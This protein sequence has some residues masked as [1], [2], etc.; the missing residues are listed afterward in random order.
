M[1]LIKKIKIYNFLTPL[2]TLFFYFFSFGFVRADTIPYHMLEPIPGIG[3]DSTVTN[4]GVYLSQV[5]TISL[6]IATVLAVLMISYG[7]FK[8]IT[9][10]SFVGKSDAKKKIT[11]AIIGLVLLLV[12]WLLLYTINPDLVN[13]DFNIPSPAS[14]TTSFSGGGGGGGFVSNGSGGG[15]GGNGG[16]GG[17][18]FGGNGSGGNSGFGGGGFSG[19]W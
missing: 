19:K 17:G 7:G 3:T 13:N 10:E 6:Q 5:F 16:S 15:S 8:Y 12:S 2:L 9:V 18:G 14:S 1:Y 4:F 11:D